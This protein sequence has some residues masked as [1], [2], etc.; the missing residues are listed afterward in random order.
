MPGFFVEHDFW[1]ADH[2]LSAPRKPSIVVIAAAS[3]ADANRENQMKRFNLLTALLTFL[4]GTFAA[5]DPASADK[6]GDRMRRDC[7]TGASKC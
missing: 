5:M 7:A 6:H 4:A 2:R 1:T 3:A